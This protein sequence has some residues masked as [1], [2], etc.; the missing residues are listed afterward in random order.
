M[1]W[2]EPLSLLRSLLRP[3]QGLGM[4]WGMRWGMGWMGL[5]LILGFGGQMQALA[6]PAVLELVRGDE[7]YPPFEM[8]QQ[9]ELTGLHVEMV[10]AVAKSLALQ[11]NWRSLPWKRALLMVET[12]QADAVTYISRT[13]EREAWAVFLEGNQLSTAEIRF[14]ARKEAAARMEFTGDVPA[15]LVQ[16]SLLTV[17]GYQFGQPEIDRAKRI[18]TSSMEDLVRRLLAGHASV[19]AVSWIDFNALYQNRPEFAG[20]T[21]LQPPILSSRNYIAFSIARGNAALAQRFAEAL[22]RYKQSRAYA[23][24]LK[25]YQLPPGS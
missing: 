17:R 18:E 3:L 5:V 14:I 15:F 23:Q 16:H 9:G 19:A 11:V 22:G 8:R 7:D 12:G 25:K 24:L 10:E 2:S 20:I 1:S 4:R 6:Q 13:P 21:A